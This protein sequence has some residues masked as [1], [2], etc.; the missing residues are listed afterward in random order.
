MMKVLHVIPSISKKR[1][2]PS[3]AV[4][5]MA[6]ALR[7]EGIDVS[8]L[9]TSD[10]STYF[11]CEY[12]I[13]QWFMIEGIPTLMFRPLNSRVRFIREYLVSPSLMCWLARNIS[14]YDAIHVH[15]I[16]SSTS[17]FAMVIA[18]LNNIPYLIRT[19]GQLNSWSLAQSRFRKRLMLTLIEKSNLTSSL[20]VH[21]TSDTE[22]SD[23]NS[24]GIYKNIICLQLGV[25]YPQITKLRNRRSGDPVHFIFLS[26]IHPKK[27]LNQL[28]AACSLL[29]E[30]C[31]DKNWLLSISGD[32]E[33]EYVRN[34]KYLTDDYGIRDKVFWTGHIDGEAKADLLSKAD[35]FILP[36]ASE[37]FGIAAVEALAYGVPVIITREVGISDSVLEY[38]AGI[39]C[40]S[41]PVNLFQ[42]LQDALDGPSGAMRNAARKL[43]HDKYSWQTIAK[44]LAS[45]YNANIPLRTRS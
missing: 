30:K 37:N 16:F 11:D 19:I 36:S 4:L 27:Q 7:N 31:I 2:G 39:I 34:M 18:R 25:D 5:K 8:I 3:I 42:V 17:T 15:S 40:D 20:A 23:L 12:P 10:N 44:K 35:W 24:L 9:T 43:A 14:N 6:R 1:G 32:G 33:E 22:L 21:V 28:L 41:D 13:A 38:K 45:F 29:N 26:R